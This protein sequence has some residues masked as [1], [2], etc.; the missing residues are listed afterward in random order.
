M[1]RTSNQTDVNMDKLI[2]V[3]EEKFA[4]SNRPR[5]EKQFN[6]LVHAASDRHCVRSH[7]KCLVGVNVD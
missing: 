4:I 5:M 7:S 6:T 2:P 1:W 3:G